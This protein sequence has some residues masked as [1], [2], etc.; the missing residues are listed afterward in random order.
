MP[1]FSN[2]YIKAC[3]QAEHLVSKV[4]GHEPEALDLVAFHRDVAA[5]NAGN[6]PDLPVAV[7][8]QEPVD[9]RKFF[10][11]GVPR[12]G[13]AVV[14]ALRSEIFPVYQ[15]LP[16][17][18]D[19]EAG[20]DPMTLVHE[21]LAAVVSR[22]AGW[23]VQWHDDLRDG[24]GAWVRYPHNE[25]RQREP[26]VWDHDLREW[27]APSKGGAEKFPE[28]KTRTIDVGH[29]VTTTRIRNRML[30]SLLFRQFVTDCLDRMRRC[31]WGD[32]NVVSESTIEA[33]YESVKDVPDGGT[34]TADI[35]GV[36]EIPADLR[37]DT[38]GVIWMKVDIYPYG[39]VTTALFPSEH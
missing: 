29:L 19:L 20:G 22:A 5:F 17:A 6:L 26:E 27:C 7:V 25:W 15:D 33:N 37:K 38:E 13:P 23:N 10:C 12:S 8:L 4:I 16:L 11:L 3:Q 21:N 34:V 32:S 36:Y 35:L 24:A 30:D 18:E 9:G 39:P 31:D 1:W 14:H 2:N 28:L